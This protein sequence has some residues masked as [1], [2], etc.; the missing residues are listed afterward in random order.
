MATLSESLTYDQL[1][2]KIQAGELNKHGY[3]TIT[4]FATVH[5]M[6][7]SYG[8]YILD[9]SPIMSAEVSGSSGLS[10]TNRI[11]H[12]G[13]NEP[14]T[15]MATSSNTLAPEAWSLTHPT[16]VLRYSWNASGEMPRH[17]YDEEFS[18]T[19]EGFKGIITRREDTINNIKTN[20]DFREI[21]YR[22]FS[23]EQPAW[24]AQVYYGGSVVQFGNII[25]FATDDVQE[26]DIPG[27][28]P[29]WIKV[30]DITENKYLSYGYYFDDYDYYRYVFNLRLTINPSDFIDRT[31]FILNEEQEIDCF[32]IIF[33]E[34]RNIP[35]ITYEHF[36]RRMTYGVNCREMIYGNY[37]Q[38]MTYESGCDSMT[39]GS[40]CGAMTYG[41]DCYEMNYGSD[42][43]EMTYGSNCYGMSYGSSCYGMNYG[44]G[45]GGMTY[46]S[47]CGAMT[48]GSKCYGMTYGNYCQ[49]MT[50]GSG[51][52]EMNYG[53]G[54]GAM[55]YG[56]GCGEITYGS[57]CRAMTYGSNCGSM[58]FPNNSTCNDFKDG[59]Y[60]FDFT[61]SSTVSATN[62]THQL[63]GNN[64]ICQT[65]IVSSETPTMV[66]TT[67]TINVFQTG[68]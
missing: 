64:I 16:D 42:C 11:I 43:Y 14:I 24:T 49:R 45:C 55:T 35:Y 32:D 5:W 46:G 34:S 56:S 19:P 6:V 26:T 58:T 4:D 8:D 47:D 18:S 40:G 1:V 17:F 9:N 53:S 10:G 39:Y 20:Y 59:V 30:I 23:I 50:Y 38:I 54:C 68:D 61:N 52:Y 33:A 31:M 13:A 12:T 51:C 22:L 7:T 29:Y 28:S 67:N 25:Y 36:C 21:T 48:Y 57:N 44:S 27:E 66:I 63:S 62:V 41:S 37:C 65:Y 60:G 2:A 3:Y 15:V